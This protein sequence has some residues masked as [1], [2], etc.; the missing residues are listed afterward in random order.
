MRHKARLVV[1]VRKLPCF[2]AHRRRFD[3]SIPRNDGV[4]CFWLRKK[5][6]GRKEERKRLEVAS[7][8]IELWMEKRG[9]TDGWNFF[10][11]FILYFAYREKESTIEFYGAVKLS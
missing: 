10:V 6:E 3:S 8:S 4:A 2:R 7:I 1:R 11:Q 5:K 9:L